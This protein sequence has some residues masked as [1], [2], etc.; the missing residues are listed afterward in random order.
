MELRAELN[1]NETKV[2]KRNKS[3]DGE[4]EGMLGTWSS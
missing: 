3:P 2:I 4:I 1:T